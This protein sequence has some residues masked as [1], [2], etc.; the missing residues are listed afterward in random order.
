LVARLPELA[1]RP[2]ARRPVSALRERELLHSTGIG[3]A[4]LCPMRAMRW[5]ASWTGRL[6]CSG[7]TLQRHSYGA[8]DGIPPALFLLVAPT[9]QQHLAILAR[10]SRLLR[11]VRPETNC[12]SPTC[13][14][15][16][17]LI[18][19]SESKMDSNRANA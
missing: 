7:D 12:W 17:L 15:S 8:V 11:D 4:S 13:R 14:K 9:V 18:R 2:D 19:N 16:H 6:S 1:A 5:R 10:I 3:G